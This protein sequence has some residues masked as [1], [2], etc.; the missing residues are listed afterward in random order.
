MAEALGLASAVAG[1]VT[2]IGQVTKLSYV[3][4][5]DV[6]SAS[7]SQKLYLQ[8]IS[9]L[10][11][12]LLRVEQALEVQE[13]DVV[14]PLISKEALQNSQELL[15]SVKTSL[16]KATENSSHI[17]KLKSSLTWPFGEKEIK[18]LVEILHRY[19]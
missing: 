17:G 15:I 8:E 18:R 9:A 19:R 2:L 4:L 5:S 12:V 6:R 7:K 3:F 16:E 11:E 1:L 14:R 10:T 13:L